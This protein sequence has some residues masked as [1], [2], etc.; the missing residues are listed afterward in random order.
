M[1]DLAD[2]ASELYSQPL[3]EFTAAR[4]TRA[5]ALD[6]KSLAKEV[7]A[8]R[9]PSASAWLLNMMAI[10][11]EKQ[12]REALTLGAAMREAQEQLDRSELKK[13]GAQRQQLI[14]ALVKD[15]VALSEELGHPAS[16]AAALEVEQTLRAAMA[17]AG[18]AAAV[19]TGRLVRPLEATGWEAVDLAG[20]VGGPFDAGGAVNRGDASA[21]AADSADATKADAAKKAEDDRAADARADLEDAEDHFEEAGSAL[22]RA[23]ERVDQL[24]RDRDA[25]VAQVK[26]LRKRI[27]ALEQ[28]IDV[29]DDAADDA[30]RERTEADRAAKESARELERARKALEKLTR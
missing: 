10:H 1:T 6:D 7:R 28:D 27:R 22:K 5:K 16:S 11:R 29:I 25:L 17:D 18:A 20:A 8:L 4:N 21:D 23:H 30:V 26:D 3:D 15:G 12:L 9:K 19:A 14:S 2:I 13:L 24:D